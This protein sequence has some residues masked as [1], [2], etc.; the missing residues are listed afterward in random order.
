MRWSAFI[1]AAVLGVALPAKA[2]LLRLRDRQTREGTIT[3]HAPRTL[4]VAGQEVPLEQLSHAWLSAEVPAA[5]GLYDLQYREYRG[6]WLALPDFEA[7]KPLSAASAPRNR[8][9]LPAGS[10]EQLGLVFDGKLMVPAAGA[11]S[12]QL[13]SADGARLSI[14]GKIVVDNDGL[15]GPRVR[16]GQVDLKP[17]LHDFRLAYFNQ[18]ATP[19]LELEWTGPSVPASRLSGPAPEPLVAPATLPQFADALAVPVPGA[20]AWNGSFLPFPVRAMDDSHLT[21]QGAPAGVQLTTTQAAVLIFTPLTS[22]RAR[23]L[24][25][26]R[27]GVLQRSGEFIEAKVQ[28]I[29]DGKLTL[30]SPLLGKRTL[31]LGADA[32]A[33]VLQPFAKPADRYTLRTRSGMEAV[34]QDLTF[35]ND[36]VVLEGAPF[37]QLRVAR[38]ELLEIH[39]GRRANLLQASW[40]RWDGASEAARRLW[41]IRESAIDQAAQSHA[42]AAQQR[43]QLELREQ[44]ATGRLRDAQ[45]NATGMEAR[46]RELKRA[47]EPAQKAMAESSLAF[48]LRVQEMDLARAVLDKAVQQETAALQAAQSSATAL[49][50]AKK[51]EADENQKAAAALVSVVAAGEKA[52]K[53][54]QERHQ[55]SLKDA[56]TASQTFTKATMARVESLAA[57]ALCEQSLNAAKLALSAAEGAITK[58]DATLTQARQVHTT[59]A[60]TLSQAKSAHATALTAALNARKV[61]E[62][63]VTGKLKPAIA[64]QQRAQQAVMG[65][66]KARDVADEELAV[67]NQLMPAAARQHTAA[68]THA[69]ATEAAVMRLRPVADQARV[70]LDPIAL[71]LQPKSQQAKATREAMFNLVSTRHQPDAATYAAA[72]NSLAIALA[73]RK[74]AETSLAEVQATLTQVMQQLAVLETAAQAADKEAK[75]IEA[76]PKEPKPAKEKARA[77]AKAKLDAAA[78]AKAA[79]DKLV[80]VQLPGATQRVAA[81]APAVVQAENAFALA[82][83]NLDATNLAVSAA[84]LA[85]VQ[86]EQARLDSA[87]KELRARQAWMDAQADFDFA[88]KLAAV[89]KQ[90]AS[91]AKAALDQLQAQRLQPA[92]DRVASFAGELAKAQVELT[93]STAALPAVNGEVEAARQAGIKGEQELKKHADTLHTVQ[94]MD[95]VTKAQLAAAEAA[96]AARRRESQAAMAALTQ[97][98]AALA[99]AKMA[100]DQAS[101]A[102]AQ[103]IKAATL[104]RTQA[105]DIA[106]QLALR[107]AKSAEETQAET[108]RQ[109]QTKAAFAKEAADAMA[110]HEKAMAS[111]KAAE[112]ARLDAQKLHQQADDAVKAAQAASLARQQAHAAALSTAAQCAREGHAAAAA[113]DL[114]LQQRDAAARELELF[115]LAHRAVLQLR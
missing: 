114:A 102:E 104:A 70:A 77:G 61:F 13:G 80:A 37:R 97:A 52:V 101:A 27:P 54:L 89:K 63:A 57:L 106:Q 49:A 113:A 20:F 51:R 18:S 95:T 50:A 1:A 103:Q 33:A 30:Q 47:V 4:R 26:L 43:L 111:T 39:H 11:H 58:A 35:E 38:V 9:V 25:A 100:T 22:T 21:L 110:A 76:D 67:A 96:A 16:Q 74:A 34:V 36:A 6:T 83:K 112:G 8:I 75:A 84:T 5:A 2:D 99:A 12:F 56:E 68:Q 107:K 85:F 64:R 31:T 28:S 93:A 71:N 92:K 79:R 42:S 66:A 98:G 45:G 59:G 24:R 69:A 55:K 60:N 19:F 94:E 7:L 40:E 90:Q 88:S 91:D 65:A 23:A 53:E 73:A 46:E 32:M 10:P 14:D 44:E 86:A 87:Q 41:E 81:A 115:L 105:L 82:K 62:D 17:G 78:V 48:G 72:T 29:A 108:D 109:Q 3:L 15:H